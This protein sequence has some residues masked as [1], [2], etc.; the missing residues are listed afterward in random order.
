MTESFRAHGHSGSPCLIFS[1]YLKPNVFKTK[2][3]KTAQAN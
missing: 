3:N 2:P 1:V